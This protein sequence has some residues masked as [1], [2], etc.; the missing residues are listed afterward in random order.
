MEIAIV[1]DFRNS[2]TQLAIADSIEHSNRHL[3]VNTKYR[4]IDTTTLDTDR[5]AEILQNTNGIWSATGCPF[6]SMNGS[7][8]AIR[9]ARENQI[10]HIG[11]CSGFQHTIIEYARNVLGYQ[12]AQHAEYTNDTDNLFID[13]MACS[14]KGTRGKV[15]I[16]EYTAANKI[17][18]TSNIEVDYYCSYGINEAYR[19]L[20]LSGDLIVSGMDVNHTIRMMELK[21]HPFFIVTAFV[22]QMDSSFDNPNPLITEFI[23][24]VN[25]TL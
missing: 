5:Y 9:Y 7:L 24:K 3:G 23:R 15:E 21:N 13:L 6:R 14:L 1:G 18:G 17:Y 25:K 19:P 2:K 22:P 16:V 12:N 20:I 11:T 8:N 10:P 4:W